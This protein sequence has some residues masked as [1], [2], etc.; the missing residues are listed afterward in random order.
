MRAFI[1]GWALLASAL[2]AVALEP[3]PKQFSGTIVHRAVAGDWIKLHEQ[4][5][6]GVFDYRITAPSTPGWIF[7]SLSPQPLTFSGTVKTVA[8]GGEDWDGDFT[9]SG[10]TIPLHFHLVDG[11]PAG[12]ERP[13]SLRDVAYGSDPRQVMDVYLARPGEAAAKTPVAV[14][15]HGGGW[16]AGDKS[17]VAHYQ[18]L[19]NAGISVV[20]IRYRYCPPA[21]PDAQTPA[22]AIPLHDAARAIQFIRS[23][24]D[25]WHLDRSRL[26][27]WG[28]S[29]GACTG[30]WLATHADLADPRSA[31]PVAR[32]STRPSCV[33][34]IWPQT[35]LDPLEMRAWVGPEITYGAHAFGLG[36]KRT[37]AIFQRFVDERERLLPWIREYSPSAL[38]QRE[39]PPLFLDYLD[40]SLTP[41]EAL[42]AYYTHSPRFGLGFLGR[43]QSVGRPCYLRYEGREDPTFASWQAFLLAE[44]APRS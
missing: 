40:F 38:V 21:N 29:A 39:G 36:L 43:C 1:T 6:Q 17:D 30:L 11:R 25:V 4:S 37:P 12:S 3:G 18:P 10:R 13:P 24:A 33:A 9:V 44:L 15:I 28:I 5:A 31:D 26:G 41:C 7:P 2:A 14:Y 42:D 27:I 23:R 22:V 35:S 8:P 20:A 32:E 34:A 16:T 19:L